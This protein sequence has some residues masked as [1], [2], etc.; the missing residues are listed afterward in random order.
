VGAGLIVAQSG[1]SWWEDVRAWGPGGVAFGL[2]LFGI[3]VPKYV[4][5]RAYKDLADVRAQRD[6]LVAQQAEVIP[7]LVSVQENMMPTLARTQSALD[8]ATREI[9]E[10]RREVQ[11]LNGR[12]PGA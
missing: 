8:A 6:A 10:L 2:I 1:P 7:V 4:L 11:R 12:G 5:D 9:A 3:M